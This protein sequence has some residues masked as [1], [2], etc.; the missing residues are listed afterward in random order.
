MPTLAEAG[1]KGETRDIVADN[2]HKDAVLFSTF[3]EIRIQNV[4]EPGRTGN[5]DRGSF[6]LR[7]MND[8]NLGLN[9]ILQPERL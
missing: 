4:S 2:K 5:G 6:F 1:S 8:T 7:R 3:F 9:P